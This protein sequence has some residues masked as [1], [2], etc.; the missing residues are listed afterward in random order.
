MVQDNAGPSVARNFGAKYAKGDYFVF[1]DSDNIAKPD[2]I[3]K[4]CKI[5]RIFKL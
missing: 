5:Y 2:M 3:E 4:F 1:L